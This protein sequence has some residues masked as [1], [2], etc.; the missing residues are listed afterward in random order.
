VKFQG[1]FR[2]G[3]CRGPGQDTPNGPL[4]HEHYFELKANKTQQIQASPSTAYIYIGRESLYQ[5]V[6]VKRFRFTKETYL[7]K[8][9]NFILQTFPLTFLLMVFLPFV[10]S[11][12]YPFSLAHRSL[13]LPVFGIS[14]LCGYKTK[15]DFLS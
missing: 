9:T 4:W 5:E 13:M 6:T 12:S 7:P 10:S 14:C 1:S 8:R 15:S 2:G 3:N 11:D